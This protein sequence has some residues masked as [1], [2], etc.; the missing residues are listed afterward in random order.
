MTTDFD[1]IAGPDL[2]WRFRLE[3]HVELDM[4]GYAMFAFG[5]EYPNVAA[6]GR[7]GIGVGLL[8][9]EHGALA[10]LAGVGVGGLYTEWDSDGPDGMPVHH[11]DELPLLGGDVGI[12]G[13]LRYFGWFEP[14]LG[15][16]F[17]AVAELGD[18]DVGTF[19]WLMPALGVRFLA[20]PSFAL[21]IEWTNGIYFFAEADAEVDWITGASLALE[22]G[23]NGS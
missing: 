17:S 2:G 20:N 1:A 11:V 3:E 23:P 15:F 14:Y 12:A 7:V 16:R 6:M 10:L 4:A 9:R 19:I 8:E 5:E 18:D 22:L 13:S 21:S